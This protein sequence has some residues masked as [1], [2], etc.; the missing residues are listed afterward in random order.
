MRRGFGQVL[1]VLNAP[2]AHDI[3][4]ENAALPGI[5]QIFE[6]GCEKPGQRAARNRRLVS[7]HARHAQIAYSLQTRY[8]DCAVSEAT[9][10]ISQGGVSL[11]VAIPEDGIDVPGPRVETVHRQKAT[12]PGDARTIADPICMIARTSTAKASPPA[13]GT[14]ASFNPIPTSS[15]PVNSDAT[16]DL[17]DG[18][19]TVGLIQIKPRV[20]V[21]CSLP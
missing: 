2:L 18:P 12:G 11:R 8:Q 21:R 9:L 20:R 7:R 17:A 19:R 1:A 14:A 15:D 3:E 13:S 5:D 6:G 10:D 4:E 16:F